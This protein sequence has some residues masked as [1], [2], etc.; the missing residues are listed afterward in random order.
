MKHA[1][2]KEELQS[3]ILQ[4][5]TLAPQTT[6]NNLN[7]YK[8][9]FG[10][11]EFFH[12]ASL[13]FS[14][15]GPL[16]SLI[17]IN[18]PDSDIDAFLSSQFYSN[19]E[20]VRTAPNDSFAD[21]IR[22]IS[23]AKSKY[24]C[25]YEPNQ[26]CCPA[27]IFDMVY[28]LEQ[29]SSIDLVIAARSF[30]DPSGSIIASSELPYSEEQP[31]TIIDGTLLLQYSIN[32]HKNIFGNL[33]TLMVTTLHA[34]KAFGGAFSDSFS[35]SFSDITPSKINVIR[36]LSFLF[37]LLID[38]KIR[39]MDTALVSTLLQPYEDDTFLLEAYK[40]LAVSFAE[41]YSL[42]ISPDWKRKSPPCLLQPLPE[43]TFFYT[44]MGEYYNL[45]PIAAEAK[46]RG[47]QTI[48]TSDIKQKAEIGIYCQHVC[49]PGNAKFSVILLHDMAQ[50][51]NRWPNIWKAE[52][53]NHFDIGIVPGEMWAS[54]WSKCA[55]QSYANPRHGVY[56]FGYPKSDLVNS[57]SLERQ[58][59]E[60]RKQLNFKYDF[61]ILYAPSWEY[62]EKEDDFVRALASLKVNLLIK[63][64]HWSDEYGYI[65]H[66]IEQMRAMHE[67]QYDNVYYIE[68]RESIMTALKLCDMVVSDESSVMVEALMF[69]KPSIA[70]TDWLIPDT[71]PARCAIM[72][73][74]CF[75]KCKKVELREY[76]EK[77]ISDP[78]YYHS[79]LEKGS[80]F[81]S[82]QGSVCT[83]I[84]DAIEYYAFGQKEKKKETDCGF[85][86][87]KLS[88]DYATCSLW[89]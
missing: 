40:K 21:I 89:N 44:D 68:P 72:P 57:S 32:E 36:S 30:I 16:V 25:F 28:F 80:P 60:L 77:L 84:M 63:Q 69:H 2:L 3:V 27:K 24:L 5:I 59:Q 1:S 55:C 43:I 73:I 62:G 7:I 13:A 18:C 74:D 66:N 20:V 8:K 76:T 31:D 41:K 53:W 17:C 23:T 83:D 33:S 49:Y 19:L 82:N 64:A 42:A 85:L 70:V 56:A 35:D 26:R 6:Y 81:F 65:I 37:H 61:S 14:Q 48:F 9:N 75:I 78:S 50:G 12:R 67:N 10:V 34:Q 79:I 39:I 58:A 52:P 38:A 88:S 29:L 71:N 54:F 87:K 47:Y 51:H 22:Y 46:K 4:S 86:S 15:Q 45:E 11:D